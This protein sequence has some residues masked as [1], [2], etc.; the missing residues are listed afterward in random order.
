M[1]KGDK[2]RLK[3]SQIIAKF[4]AENGLSTYQETTTDPASTY[5]AETGV[6]TPVNSPHQCYMVFDEIAAEMA[7]TG[8]STPLDPKYLLESKLCL[9]AGMDISVEPKEDGFII[10]AGSTTRHKIN[11][12]ITDMYK[13]LYIL[14]INRKPE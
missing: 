12:V 8:N 9:I 10:P 1:T 13:A 11:K 4:A 7:R 5:D 6:N 3:A 2:F 14:Y